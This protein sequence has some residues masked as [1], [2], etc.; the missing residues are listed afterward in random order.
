MQFLAP[1][2]QKINK[3]DSIVQN[4]YHYYASFQN[5][6]GL[7]SKHKQ[8]TSGLLAGENH[9]EYKNF[10]GKQI[11][12]VHKG[13]LEGRNLHCFVEYCKRNGGR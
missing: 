8:K 13:K 10:I 6:S 3:K 9:Y 4:I 5:A 1:N 7:S 12:E 2:N 11:N